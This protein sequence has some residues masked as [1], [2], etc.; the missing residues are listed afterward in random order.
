MERVGA[1]RSASRSGLD[2]GPRPC[3][4]ASGV[5]M[6]GGERSQ[7]VPATLAGVT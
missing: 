4:P 7:E 5:L 2:A 1:L 6:W 3:Q